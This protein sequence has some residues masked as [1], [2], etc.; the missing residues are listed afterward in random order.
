MIAF[1]CDWCGQ[2]Y[3]DYACCDQGTTLASVP[4]IK[5]SKQKTDDKEEV[6]IPFGTKTIS[7]GW[8]S[9]KSSFNVELNTRH[10]CKECYNAYT[11]FVK[12]RKKD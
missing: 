1:I 12:S 4:K 8:T 7:V 10:V 5:K 9:S 11:E 2:T 6:T 3:T